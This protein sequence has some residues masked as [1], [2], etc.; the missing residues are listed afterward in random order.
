MQPPERPTMKRPVGVTVIAVLNFCAAGGLAVNEVLMP[1]ER[2]H[3][4]GLGV[5]IVGVL[6]S[7]GLG[8][9]L[10][11]LRN[12]ARSI[13]IFFC[14]LSLVGVF[15]NTIR[16]V[17]AGQRA[18]AVGELLGGLLAGWMLWYL[19]KAE[20][21]AAFRGREALAWRESLSIIEGATETPNSI[22]QNVKPRVNETTRIQSLYCERELLRDLQEVELPAEVGA[23]KM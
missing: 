18:T 13:T 20:V 11:K 6:F 17:L 7:L 5:L 12:W 14:W 16:L 23:I 2:P 1:A 15:I 4:V 9:G 8:L 22:E 19:S 21:I 3:G 10:L